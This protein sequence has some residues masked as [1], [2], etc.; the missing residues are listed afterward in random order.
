MSYTF[1]DRRSVG[2]SLKGSD[3]LK[4]YAENF[5][6]LTQDNG[7]GTKG[8]SGGEPSNSTQISYFGRLGYTYDSRYSV[9]VNFRADAYDTSKLSAK[10]RWGYFPSVSAGWT[11]SNERWIKDN[12]SR[13]ALSFLKIRGS[14][15][16]N[17]NIAVLSGYPYSTSISYNSQSYQFSGSSNELTLG[18]IPDGLANPDLKWETSEQIDLGLDAR[19]LN[20][21]LTF[22]MDW[23]NKDTRDLLVKISPVAEVGISSTTVNAGSVNNHGFEFELGWQ[24]TVGDFHYSINANL[25]TLSNKVTYLEPSVGHITGS[26]F[27]NYKLETYF[28]EGYPV[29][30][31][32][33]F[34]YAGIGED[35]KAQFYDKDGNITNAPV[36][37][38]LKYIG[39]ALPPVSYGATI[40]MEWKGIDLT[41]FGTGAA[42]HQL[43]PC[44][45]R[46]QHSQINS[47]T[48]YYENAGKT[49]PSIAN[50]WTDVN[51][52]SS[53]ATLFRGDYFKIKQIQLG[54][55]LPSKWTK[56]IFISNLRFYVSLDDYIVFTKY[57]GF[58][59]ETASTGSTSGSGLDKGSYPNAKKALFGV[60]IT[61]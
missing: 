42:G 52:W 32:R 30:Y 57:P 15:G 51:F 7:S 14:W 48:W 58:D 27:A 28:E 44:V 16:I 19:F 36:D 12:V 17:G 49:I 13:E 5:R 26:G 60:N 40:Q 34:E 55:T 6:Y 24:D 46:T 10:N 35:G 25:S 22:T 53:S 41:I 47:L 31:L 8:I 2:A 4:G 29:W 21:R 9:Q 43:V 37:A 54:Y 59:P 33:G 50:M 45:Y 23:Y 38:D 3:P 1:S 18:S 20:N 61:F 11:L 56:K 39:S